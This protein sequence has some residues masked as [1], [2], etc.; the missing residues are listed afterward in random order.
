MAADARLVWG[1][2]SGKGPCRWVGVLEGID[3][4]WCVAGDQP[5]KPWPFVVLEVCPVQLSP[6]QAVGVP[7]YDMTGMFLSQGTEEVLNF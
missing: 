3:E 7:P 1:G 2:V 6:H 4:A 5:P